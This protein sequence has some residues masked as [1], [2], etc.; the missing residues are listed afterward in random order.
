MQSSNVN[1]VIKTLL[2]FLSFF[3]K[4]F[5]THQKHSKTRKAPEALNDIKTLGQKHKNANKR[6]SDYFPL[7]CFLGAFFL[8]LFACKRFVLFCGCEVFE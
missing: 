4:T 1:E 8:F 6:I 2:N 7:R 3:T 5:D